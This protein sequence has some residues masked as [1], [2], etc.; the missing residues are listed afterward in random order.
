MNLD[1]IPEEF[2]KLIDTEMNKNPLIY[3]FYKRL[4]DCGLNNSDDFGEY[5]AKGLVI[6]LISGNRALRDMLIRV[7]MRKS[8]ALATPEH[9]FNLDHIRQSPTFVTSTPE[10][11]SVEEFSKKFA[12]TNNM[13]T[14]IEAGRELAEKVMHSMA[15]PREMLNLPD[16]SD[17][18]S[19]DHEADSL[20]RAGI[21]PW[22]DGD[23]LKALRERGDN[24]KFHGGNIKADS[25]YLAKTYKSIDGQPDI[26][27]LIWEAEQNRTAP[28]NFKIEVSPESKKQI[29][30]ILNKAP[31]TFNGV[32][33]AE[34]VFGGMKVEELVNIEGYFV[35][36]MYDL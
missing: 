26:L 30:N 17:C 21:N 16:I 27:N 5:L 15:V 11:M 14:G 1:T 22:F 12:G 33:A 31:S 25:L 36:V 34:N 19:S 28:G 6:L 35:G 8:F 10:S 18:K 32:M 9:G 20:W 7:S 4:T 2:E 24:I 29:M 3:S 13:V 23:A